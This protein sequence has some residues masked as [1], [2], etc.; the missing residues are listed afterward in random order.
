MPEM[1]RKDFVS[2]SAVGAILLVSISILSYFVEFSLLDI[3]D[4]RPTGID[5][6]WAFYLTEGFLVTMA[7]LSI[8]SYVRDR[9]LLKSS[10]SKTMKVGKPKKSLVDDDYHISS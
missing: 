7:C 6:K 3:F 8:S 4:S 5:E 2:G 9:Q 10:R 1:K